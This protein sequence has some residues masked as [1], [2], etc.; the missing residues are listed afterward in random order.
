MMVLGGHKVSVSCHNE[1]RL[2]CF[3]RGTEPEQGIEDIKKGSY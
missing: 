3:D 1:T 2:S